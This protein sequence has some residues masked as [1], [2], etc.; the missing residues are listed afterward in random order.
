MNHGRLPWYAPGELDPEQRELYD[1]IA[2]GP[3]AAGPQAFPLTDEAGRLNGPFNAM[4]VSPDIGATVQEV[5]AAIRYRSALS[6]RER[7]IA[8]LEVSVLRRCE[9]EWY[10]HERVGR[11]NG[12]SDDELRALLHGEPAGTFDSRETI[13]RRVAHDALVDRTLAD[14]VLNE[15]ELALGTRALMDVI[16]LVGYYDLLALK[17]AVWQTPLPEGAKPVFADAP[18]G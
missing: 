3:R 11:A 14:D 17:M 6:H 4:L 18:K 9:F 13:V 16:T 8:I 10:A 7:E 15:A 2:G 5:G 1:R 12:L